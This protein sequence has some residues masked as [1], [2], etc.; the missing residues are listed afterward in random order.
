MKR[1]NLA[2]L[3]ALGA[4]AG[5]CL[6]AQAQ[7][8]VTGEDWGVDARAAVVMEAG[9]RRLLFSQNANE[10]LPIASTT[11]IMTALL[12][13]EQPAPDEVFFADA[14]AIC[15]EGSSM[16]LESGDA[17]T[18]RA[19]AGGMLMASGNDAAN[20][21]A[22]R[23]AGSIEA[24]AER[25][26]ARAAELGMTDTH[27]VTP[28]GLDAED[29][30]STARDMALLACAALENPDFAAMVSSRSLTLSY[31]NPP[32]LRRLYNHNRL[33]DMY[34][35][36]IGIKTG[37]TK[38][39]GR[40]LVSAARRNGV[41][42]V[43]VTLD[44][45]DDWNVHIALYERYFAMVEQTALQPD[46]ELW[47]PVVGGEEA[48]VTLTQTSELS[49]ARVRGDPETCEARVFCPPFLYAPVNQG[50]IVGKIVYYIG[51]K[52][53]GESALEASRGVAAAPGAPA[54]P[55]WQFWKREG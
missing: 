25:M 15:V 43:C 36:C 17:V 35:A 47:A 13:L 42:L 21:A 44:C 1:S 24:F 51:E 49:C 26:N 40:C 22:V 27:F 45:P 11:K 41:T 10:R 46:R 39:S 8:L 18:L 3:L 19:L 12:T 29:H 16:G 55:W 14:D 20:A 30:R 9:S 5:A 32:Y 4:L 31:G 52:A 28:S 54:P 37:F 33:L 53:V 6:P 34:S 2:A 23:I 7:C 50:D 48:R 38:K